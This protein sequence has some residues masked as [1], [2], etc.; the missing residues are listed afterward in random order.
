M[1]P[2]PATEPVKTTVAVVAAPVAAPAEEPE[3]A[4]T[5]PVV[6]TGP[7]EAATKSEERLAR[8]ATVSKSDMIKRF[9]K[10]VGAAHEPEP[11][12]VVA[13]APIPAAIPVPIPMPTT[14]PATPEPIPVVQ[15]TE[16]PKLA[17]TQ[18]D[19]LKNLIPS[20][21]AQP[22]AHKPNP[23]AVLATTLAI[24]IMGGYIWMHNVG[25]LTITAAAQKAGISATL[26]SYVPAS[27]SLSGPISYGPGYLTMQFSSPSSPGPLVL[28]QRRTE[29]SS[30]S[31]L[32][33][34]VT[35][36]AKDYV[37]VQTQGLTVY[38]Y[39]GNQATWVN[40]GMQYIVEGDTRLS[41]EQ[42][43]KIA[44]SL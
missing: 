19:G 32:E 6:T 41:K 24:A 27:Y 39:N 23:K 12:T 36:K 20:E 9:V 17:A 26:P 7:A 14:A 18:L 8:A 1:A 37:T 2:K 29:W 31:L 42:V 43:I 22:T 16:L 33:L 5:Q 40:R 44:E 34:Y 28:T 11:A 25:N 15:P 38:V 35:P 4:S 30:A 21:P 13:P 3:E 10:P